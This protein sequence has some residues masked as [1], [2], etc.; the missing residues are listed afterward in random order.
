MIKVNSQKILWTKILWTGPYL[1]NAA[2]GYFNKYHHQPSIGLCVSSGLIG[3]FCSGQVDSFYKMKKIFKGHK[4]HQLKT[5]FVKCGRWRWMIQ[6]LDTSTD[7]TRLVWLLK[8][9]KQGWCGFCTKL[10]QKILFKVLIHSF[11]QTILF[12]LQ[13]RRKCLTRK[14]IISIFFLS[15]KSKSNQAPKSLLQRRCNGNYCQLWWIRPTCGH[16]NYLIEECRRNCS[17]N[18]VFATDAKLFR[19]NFK[20]SKF[21]WEIFSSRF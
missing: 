16:P 12:F 21:S 18:Y 8:H 11:F 14:T 3:F 2:L 7:E 1:S 5:F 6:S 17:G 4:Q 9:R 20:S 15:G 19:E 10:G 13:Q